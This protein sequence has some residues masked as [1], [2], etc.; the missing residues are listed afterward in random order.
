MGKLAMW[1]AIGG[2]A[3]G[4]QKN[5]DV[6]RKREDDAAANQRE[7]ALR[8]YEAEEAAKRLQTSTSSQE[9]IA[10]QEIASREGIAG[11]ELSSR[12][13]LQ[14]E[15]IEAKKEEGAANRASAERIAGIRARAT[16][17]GRTTSKGRWNFVSQK[18]DPVIDSKT[19]EVVPG[20]VQQILRDTNRGIA[21]VQS[22]D[23][24]VLPDVDPTSTKRAAASEVRKLLENPDQADNFLATYKYLPMQFIAS[25][26]SS[27]N[28]GK[29]ASFSQ[30]EPVAQDDSDDY[31]PA[32]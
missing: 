21:F 22:G 16:A 25:Q 28:Y 7:M 14:G 26:S 11:K 32:Q 24:F 5:I 31:E 19:G 10:G 17:A 3:A 9:K 15:E 13:E 29:D 30:S 20:K 8:K 4:M 1:G 27:A 12:K 2:A 18:T 23:R 6:Q